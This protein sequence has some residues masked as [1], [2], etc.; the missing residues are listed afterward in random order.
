MAMGG[1]GW[2]GGGRGAE[3]VRAPKPMAKLPSS[4]ARPTFIGQ[5]HPPV[6]PSGTPIFM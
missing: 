5:Q 4:R 2:G 1:V 3:G 6:C